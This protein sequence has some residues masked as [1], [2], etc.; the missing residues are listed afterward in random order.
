MPTLSITRI[1][2]FLPIAVVG[3]KRLPQSLIGVCLGPVVLV[4][5]DYIK[6]K[7][8]LVHELEHSK[9]FFKGGLIVHFLRYWMST[10]YRLKVEAQAFA[11]E[12]AACPSNIAAS[13]FEESARAL[14]CGYGL[15]LSSA[16][17]EVILL[18]YLNHGTTVRT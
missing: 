2:R 6:D 12:I 14:S 16:Q 18:N 8:T 9:Q 15:A 4:S 17:C 3:T 7:P 11:A 5:R 13:R 10:D 1:W